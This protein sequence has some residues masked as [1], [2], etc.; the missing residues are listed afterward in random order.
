MT[1]AFVGRGIASVGTGSPGAKVTPQIYTTSR[2]TAEGGIVLK[3]E[4]GQPL[5][6][7]NG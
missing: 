6:V 4:T 5:E 7:E 1:I 3:T 2:I